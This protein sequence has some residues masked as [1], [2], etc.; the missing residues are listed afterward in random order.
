MFV[1]GTLYSPYEHQD[2]QP[3]ESTAVEF[4]LNRLI[5]LEGAGLGSNKWLTNAETGEFISVEEADPMSRKIASGMF[6]RGMRHGDVMLYSSHEATWL[7]VFIF[8]VWRANGTMR[9]SY[10][11][12]SIDTIVDRILESKIKWI[13]CDP[14]SAVEALSAAVKVPWEVE[15]ISFGN[16]PKGCIS[17]HEIMNDDGSAFPAFSLQEEDMGLILNTSG[18]TGASKGA[19]HTQRGLAKIFGTY[20]QTFSNQVYGGML[21]MGRPT[22][23]TGSCIPFAAL[24]AGKGLL[25]LNNVT[26]EN[27]FHAVHHYKPEGIFG[28]PKYLLY[29]ANSPDASKYD[30]SSLRV[31]STG[32]VVITP[33]FVQTMECK[34]GVRVVNGYG[35]TECG[36]F[37]ST[38]SYDPNSESKILE[39]IPDF[40]VGKLVPGTTLQVRDIDTGKPLGP[41]KEGELCFKN[42][43]MCAGYLN[44]RE[45]SEKTFPDGWLRTGDVGY[46]DEN[47]FV[48]VVDRIKE[49]FKYYNNHISPSE[50]EN[51]IQ[52]HPAVNNVC[53]VGV[54]DPEGGDSVPRAFVTLKDVNVSAHEIRQFANENMA[55]YKKLRGGLIVLPELPVGKTGKLERRVLSKIQISIPKEMSTF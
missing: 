41:N 43:L 10:P 40:S 13:L 20:A 39:N 51:I 29:L 8:G 24:S 26:M 31:V 15:V 27:I 3:E 28:F 47:G 49:I 34:L 54:P 16:P 17:A 42:E 45:E 6:K 44:K 32:G 12:D 1:D 33:S 38:R 11:E 55:S 18:T 46:F 53:V 30:F 50:L 22:H 9:A 25:Q 14:N 37:T 52:R 7:H 19:V 21:T 48:F 36:L 4:L 35:M 2:I 5:D 23:I